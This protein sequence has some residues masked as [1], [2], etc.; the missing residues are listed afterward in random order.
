M[1]TSDVPSTS[2]PFTTCAVLIAGFMPLQT[3]NAPSVTC[4]QTNAT[5]QQRGP[6]EIAALRMVIEH[7]ARRREDGERHDQRPDA[8][9]EMDGDL[10]VPDRRH[11]MAERQRE[12]RN[13]QPRVRC[14]ASSRR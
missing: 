9:R 7:V 10:R 14:A 5:Q 8:V 12:V 2:A 11:E 3:T 4:T 13:R 6:D 1:R